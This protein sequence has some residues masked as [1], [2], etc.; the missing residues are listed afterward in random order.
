MDYLGEALPGYHFALS[1]LTFTEIDPA[2]RNKT[3]DF[4]IC[5]PAIYV[6]LEVKY[7]ITR[8]MTL[9]NLVG[10]QIVSEYGGVVFCRADRSDLHNLQDVRGQRLAATGQTSFGGWYLALR[11]F[12]SA[13]IDPGRDCSRLVFLDTHPA[14]VRAVLSGEADFGTVRTDTIERMAADGQIQMDEIRVIP[15]NVA[16]VP[17][18]NFPYLHST[19]LYPEWPFAKLSGTSDELS[20]KLTVVL[21]GLPA[22]SPAATAAQSGGWGVCLDYT[23]VHDCLRELRLPPYQYSGQISLSD[24]WLHYWQWLT[25]IAALVIAL[26]SVLLLLRGRQFAVIRA[27]LLY[28]SPSPRDGLLSRMPSSA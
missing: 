20:R 28:T 14:V 22:D 17:R 11:E 21:L 23:S 10:S 16:A 25:A 12:R 13:G 8:T 3:I 5:N 18:S 19:R 4:L 27:C 6:D 7:G 24:V 1:P 2:V 26:L 15:A 9:L